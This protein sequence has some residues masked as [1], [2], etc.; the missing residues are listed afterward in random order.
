MAPL[1]TEN[2]NEMCTS[3]TTYSRF[4]EL[5]LRGRILAEIPGAGHFS[6]LENPYLSFETVCRFLHA[7]PADL[8]EILVEELGENGRQ[9]MT[10]ARKKADVPPNHC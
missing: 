8:D 4:C 6:F 3:M 7:S 2:E 1:H 5:M 9:I 10:S